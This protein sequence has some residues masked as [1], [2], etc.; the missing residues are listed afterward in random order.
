VAPKHHWG[1]AM[2]KVFIIV[3]GETEERF[4]RQVLY[5][6]FILMGIH[7]DAQ[8]WPTN[9]KLG[10]TGGGISFDLVENH[11]N[12]I[13]SRYKNDDSIFISTMIDLYQFPKQGNTIYDS[14]VE[15]LVSGREKVLLLE[16]KLAE[17]IDHRN[18]IPYVQLHEYEALL[19]AKPD[20]F[21]H[22]YIDKS[23]EIDNLIN[24]ISGLN[25]E[26]INET[27]KNAP[28]K[29]IIRHLP[30]YAKQKTTAGVLIAE[31]IGLPYL[32]EKCP[33]FNEW[34]TKLEGI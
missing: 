17:R 34:I 24:E 3:E 22:F 32:R 7:I 14:S 8:Q 2:K 13:K 12:R 27:S 23:I 18:F 9:K 21:S 29:R 26:D 19:L 28:S 11:L 5:P 33:H 20:S 31:K 4:L 25:P 6:H 10:T 1:E 16:Q 30:K 15:K